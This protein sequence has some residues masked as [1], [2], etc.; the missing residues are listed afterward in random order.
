[1]T[2]SSTEA[3]QMPTIKFTTCMARNADFICREIA[4]YV[5]EKLGVETEFIN[6]ITWQERERLLDTG[7]IDV[8]WLCGLPYVWKVDAGQ[9]EIELLAAPVM[10]GGRYNQQPIYYSDVIVRNE[11]P[12]FSF[13]DLRGTRWAI[14]ESR[15]HSGYN[16]VRHHLASLGETNGYFGAVIES[17]AHQNSLR[18]ILDGEI[19]AAAIDTTVM[20]TELAQTPELN[21][22]I[23]VI[24][25]LGPSPIPP[26]I[27]SRRIPH[28][29]RERLRELLV[30]MHMDSSGKEI[31]ERGRF[32]RFVR[33]ADDDYDSIRCMAQTAE[34]VTLL[35]E[36]S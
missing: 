27:I 9:P 22:Q 12:F 21:G 31:L 24:A 34:S 14:N 35:P 7:E 15:S 26:W 30:N 2:R 10:A 8:C 18:L 25:T 19:D 36:P 6:G 11:S 32:A 29:M 20:E 33:V 5:C 4:S 28:S 1:M 13:A 17:G 16:L 3:N 23:R